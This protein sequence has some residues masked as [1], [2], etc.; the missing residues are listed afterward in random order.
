MTKIIL[1][2]FSLLF[3]TTGW[4]ATFIL[5]NQATHFL[6]EK[7]SRMTI[8]WATSAKD[9]EEN[10]QLILQGKKINPKSLQRLTQTGKIILT[11][12]KKAQYFRILVWSKDREPDLLTNWVDIVPNKTYSL[13]A[14]YL[15]PRVLMTG[16]GC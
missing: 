4:A 15:I 13:T 7:K 3:A 10:N 2:F 9:A 8:Q 14:D 6:T 1:F 16:M 5:N 12:P 11:I